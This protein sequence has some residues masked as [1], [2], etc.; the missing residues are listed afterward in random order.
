[1]H[2]QT[3]AISG[4]S[5][6]SGTPNYERMSRGL[7]LSQD[8]AVRLKDALNALELDELNLA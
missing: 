6:F 3:K 2:L 7:T 8:E 1:M 5:G 4:F